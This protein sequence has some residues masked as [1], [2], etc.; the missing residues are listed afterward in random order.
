MIEVVKIIITYLL[1]FLSIGFV[2]FIPGIFILSFFEKSIEKRFHMFVSW[3]VGYS[4]FILLSYVGAYIHIVYAPLIFTV[5]AAIYVCLKRRKMPPINILQG[6]KLPA[7]LILFGSL[8]FTSL[9]FLSG[10][11]TKQGYEFIGRVN[12]TDGF[13]HIA[14]IKTQS[15][16]FPP[17][18]AGFAGNTMRG[19]HYFYDFLL[20][21]F[22]L[23]FHFSAEDLYFRLFPF[24]VALFYGSA[25]Y[26]IS[27]IFTKR[28]VDKVYILFFAYFGSSL[29]FLFSLFAKT[30]DPGSGMGLVQQ[31]ELILDPSIVFSAGLLLAGVFIVLQKNKTVGNAILASLIFG[32]LAQM[33]VYAGIIGM[34]TI[35]LFGIFILYKH[36]AWRYVITLWLI[37]IFLTA[38]TY[39]PNNFG[40]GTLI[41]SPFFLYDNFMKQSFF[42]SWKWEM[43]IFLYVL[44]HSIV[45]L[46]SIYILAAILFWACSLGTRFLVI[47]YLYKMFYKKFW[48]EQTTLLFFAIGFPFVLASFFVQSISIFDTVQFLWI[49]TIF[50]S[51]PA[52]VVCGHIMRKLPKLGMYLFAIVIVFL[53]WGEWYF[54][55]NIYI[56]HPNPTNITHEQ[57]GVTSKISQV[58]R[59]D[60]YFVVV[61]YFEYDEHGGRH[62]ITYPAPMF[63]ALSGRKTYY[64]YETPEYWNKVE[65]E[66]RKTQ[67]ELLAVAISK[68]DGEMIH[69]VTR[70]IKTKF[71]VTTKPV[72]CGKMPYLQKVSQGGDWTFWIVK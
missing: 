61:P 39:L 6:I 12:G 54:N 18:Y 55:E 17:I 63:A 22:V 53:S 38:A 66:H 49:V 14:H 41:V 32:L 13:M 43:R 58:L 65:I 69:I 3:P 71:F 44:H 16:A 72:S 24:V 23:F 37:T 9:S 56:F 47:V 20:S 35:F 7:L 4:L 70:D 29:G 26:L 31:L 64:E 11:I 59:K 48:K 67:Q 40:I 30:V 52:G 68:C 46:I 60:E 57:L 33:K 2:F 21:R 62:T 8:T 10:M 34:G 51:I 15:Y 27:G 5:I 45:R 42:A 25:I 1:F 28:K 36:K 19:Y 50:L